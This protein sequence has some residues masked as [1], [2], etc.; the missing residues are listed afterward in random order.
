L[1]PSQTIGIVSVAAD[2]Q[3]DGVGRGNDHVG[4]AADDLASDFGKGLGPSLSGIPIDCEVLS[5]DIA[6]SPQLFEK[7]LVE[8]ATY[9]FAT[10]LADASDG[11][12]GDDNRN[13]VLL[14]P[15]LRPSPGSARE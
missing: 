6:Q 14:R 13:A 1:T 3:R 10:R 4:V 8:A 2:R 5:L 9:G 11:A 12:S 7:R 15:L